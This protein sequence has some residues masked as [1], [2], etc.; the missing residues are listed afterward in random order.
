MHE[1]CR[2]QILHQKSHI[3]LIKNY[4]PGKNPKI[5]EKHN[6]DNDNDYK[7]FSKKLRK[8]FT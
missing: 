7:N 2:F 8:Y 3:L 5:T 4:I 6:F 1:I